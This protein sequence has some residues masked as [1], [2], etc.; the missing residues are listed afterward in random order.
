MKLYNHIQVFCVIPQK[1]KFREL[2]KSTKF[3]NP[4]TSLELMKFN[5]NVIVLLGVL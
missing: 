3:Q 2:Q 4:P 5:E 1:D